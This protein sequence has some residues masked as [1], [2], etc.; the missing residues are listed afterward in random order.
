MRYLGP[1][2]FTT[3]MNRK[4]KRDLLMGL[5]ILAAVTIGLII[6]MQIMG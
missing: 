3:A 6:L 1:A 4:Q 5:G 2:T